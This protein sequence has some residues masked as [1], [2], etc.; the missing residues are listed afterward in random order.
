MSFFGISAIF[1]P[2]FGPNFWPNFPPRR[3]AGGSGVLPPGGRGGLR[4]HRE[5][6]EKNGARNWAGKKNAKIAEVPEKYI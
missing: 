2:F 6:R 5:A 1:A 4:R 3:L